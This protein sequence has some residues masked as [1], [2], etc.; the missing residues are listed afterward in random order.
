MERVDLKV[1][2][3]C[4]NRC[5]FCVQGNKRNYLVAKH[6]KEIRN[7]LKQSFAKG[8]KEVVF[9]GGEP[10]LHPDFLE[11]VGMA[12]DMGFEEI[13]IQTNGRMFSYDDF[14]IKTIKAGATQFALALHGHNAKIH[15]FLTSA[16]GSFEQTVKGIKNLKRLNQYVLTNTV[17]TSTNARY[18]PQLAQL[19]VDLG[20]SQ[21]Q[22]AFVHISG[23]AAENKDWIVPQKSKIIKYIKKGLDVGIETNK[24]VTTEA[25]P[26]CLMRGYEEY[27]AEKIIPPSMVYDADFVVEDYAQYRKAVGKAKGPNCPKC[28]YYKICEGP[29]KEYPDIFGWSEFK[30]IK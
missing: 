29:W 24:K 11:I 26:Y 15:D 6:K 5:K 27:I 10:T 22:F 30:P 20:V 7:S 8:K 28:K 12:K 16:N 13:Q 1:G 3:R 9:T 23:R 25:I 14:C 18:L 17:I 4:N 19:L 21:Y 2:F